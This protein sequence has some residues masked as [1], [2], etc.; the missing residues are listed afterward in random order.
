MRIKRVVM[1]M[2]CVLAVGIAGADPADA[3]PKNKNCHKLCKTELKACK[4][5]CS[6]LRGREKRDCRKACRAEIFDACEANSDPDTCLGATTS[7][8]A[9]P[10]TTAPVPTTTTSTS[11]TTTTTQPYGSASRA[12]LDPVASLLQ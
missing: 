10:P 12:F 7:T 11:S 3:K 5:E 9:A 8:T 6:G 4:D 1:V 2:A